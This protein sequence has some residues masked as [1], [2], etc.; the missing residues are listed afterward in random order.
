MRLPNDSN[1]LALLGMTGSGKTVAGLWHLSLRSFNRMP[2]IIFDFKLD[3]NI[4]KIPRIIEVDHTKK[5]PTKPGLY[6]VRP[7][8][9][10][11]DEIEDYLWKIWENGNTGVFIDEGYMIDRY[12]KALRAILTQG[13]S[14]RIPV[15]MLSQRPSWICPFLLSESEYLQLFFMHNPR[16]IKTM[17]EWVPFD[18]NL[19]RNFNSVY[20]D[21]GGGKIS[22]LSPVPKENE[23]LNRFDARMPKRRAWI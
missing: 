2:W 19:P 13:R 11:A 15:I 5:P 7:S 20:F 23:I 1:R 17:R 3:N 16:D 9:H 22:Y 4:A 18:G 10:T 12:S 6:V 8:R 21:V 14:K